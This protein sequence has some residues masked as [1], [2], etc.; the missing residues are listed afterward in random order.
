LAAR[1]TKGGK[2]PAAFR[3]TRESGDEGGWSWNRVRSRSVELCMVKYCAV[4]RSRAVGLTFGASACAALAI[5][6]STSPAVAS[7]K[8]PTPLPQAI[9]EAPVAFVGTV[10]ATS[11]AD[12]T[13]EVRVEEVWKGTSLPRVV[14][15]QGSPVRG[16]NVF[17]SVDRRFRPGQRYL[18]VPRRNG[19]ILEDN[20]CSPT[21]VYDPVVAV[22]RPA[23]AR[24][25]AAPPQPAM[26]PA[27][28]PSATD[29]GMRSWVLGAAGVALVLGIVS[30]F[31]LRIRRRPANL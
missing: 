26:H 22:L 15:V 4:R 18:F 7:C 23:S 16:S 17:T 1:E 6:L 28:H 9:A 19:P 12:R 25:P 20:N 13:A 31:A 27:T 5:V 30:A 3:V 14:E 21:A 29:P 10:T 2:I 24:P 8:G 11:N